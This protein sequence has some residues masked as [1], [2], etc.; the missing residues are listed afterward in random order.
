MLEQ[1]GTDSRLG[2]LDGCLAYRSKTAGSIK[3]ATNGNLDGFDILR[4]GEL[5][6]VVHSCRFGPVPAV[7]AN[8]SGSNYTFFDQGIHLRFR[9]WWSGGVYKKNLRWLKHLELQDS[10]DVELVVTDLA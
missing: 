3:V 2:T 8:D 10:S 5:L 1:T 4:E 6:N 7:S 9:L